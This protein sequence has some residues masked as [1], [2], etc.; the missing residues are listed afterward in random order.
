MKNTNN[1]SLESITLLVEKHEQLRT[2]MI[3]EFKES[4]KTVFDEVFDM[5]PP[6]L[7]LQSV[8]FRAYTPFFNDGS[9]CEFDV[10]CYNS[11]CS[12][13]LNNL[14]QEDEDQEDAYF[15]MVKES[16][17]LKLFNDIVHAIPVD[18]WKD[19]CNGEGSTITIHKGGK[20][21]IESYEDHD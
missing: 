16:G 9:E 6:A 10:Y 12:I 18:V 21:T 14:I 2:K 1:K 19:I 5:V 8:G 17:A 13:F 11:S 20:M 7:N 4:I 3:D 15:D